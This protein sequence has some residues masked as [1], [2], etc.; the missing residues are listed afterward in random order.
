MSEPSEDETSD[1]R[2]SDVVGYE[3]W[4]K[5]EGRARQLS[6][7]TDQ[8]VSGSAG[9]RAGGKKWNGKEGG[10]HKVDEED[11][12]RVGVGGDSLPLNGLLGKG[13]GRGRVPR[14]RRRNG[15]RDALKTKARAG[16]VHRA[17][18]SESEEDSASKA[19]REGEGAEKEQRDV[20]SRCQSCSSAKGEGRGGNG[21]GSRRSPRRSPCRAR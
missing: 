5:E 13:G 15:E 21:R 16:H 8:A 17:R 20:G 7:V 3:A 9:C 11:V 18:G 19:A 1:L 4:R 6:S 10:T 14:G 12:E 2:V